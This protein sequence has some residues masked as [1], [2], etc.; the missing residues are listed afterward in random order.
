MGVCASVIASPAIALPISITGPY[1]FL[2]NVG[3]NDLG[4]QTGQLIGIGASS[5][6]P[7][8]NAG[9]T[10]TGQIL[11]QSTGLPTGP[12]IPINNASSTASPNEFRSNITYNSNLTGPWQLK[13]TNG[14]DIAFALTPGIPTGQQFAPFANNVSV[15]G[16][17]LNPTFA[18]SYP[19]SV[20]GVTVL[21][22]DRSRS[23]ATGP[24]LVF[25]HSLAG[26]TNS[27]TLPTALD[28]GL[29]LTPGTPY[30]VAL[31]GLELRTPGGQ[32]T[33]PNTASQSVSYFDF[34]PVTSGVPINLPT[35]GPGGGYMYS[36]TVL[37]GTEYFIDPSITV[38]Y[39]YQI[40][41]GDP[42]FASVQLPSIQSADFGL[43]YLYGGSWLTTV[44]TPGG[45]FDF[46]H[47]GVT[48]FD[49]TGIDPALMLN[50]GNTTAFVTGLTFTA[51]GSFTGTQTP[52]TTAVPEPSSLVIL[53]SGLG[54][55]ALRSRRGAMACPAT[56]GT[57]RTAL[58]RWL[59]G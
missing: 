30:V 17:G 47:G 21:I 37:A 59:H 1:Q 26:S 8:G 36:M 6:V 32:R 41:A 43:S 12:A 20:D 3:A 24:D 46:P 45:T 52:L 28:G 25:S 13:F 29:T 19:A 33:N 42:N 55:L 50:P 53:V 18:W 56:S 27:Y 34:T 31:K 14:P 22:Y 38:G 9:T 44:V 15:S 5:V 58:D 23:A 10:A 48:A 54:Y 57:E 16:S 11:D 40:G 35:V 49:V 7:N 51:D 39:A 4:F 2:D